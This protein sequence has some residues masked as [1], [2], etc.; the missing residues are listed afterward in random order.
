ME[1]LGATDSAAFYQNTQTFFIE[2]KVIKV[3]E[4]SPHLSEKAKILTKQ[5]IKFTPKNPEDYNWLTTWPYIAVKICRVEEKRGFNIKPGKTEN[6]IATS[7]EKCELSK[8]ESLR[9]QN[10]IIQH[11]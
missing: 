9:E 10:S 8:V 7:I 3:T 6:L 5:S 2:A 1:F 4:E 11:Q